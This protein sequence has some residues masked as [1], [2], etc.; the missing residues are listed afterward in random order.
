MSARGRTGKDRVHGDRRLVDA[1]VLPFGHGLRKPD[2]G[3]F[4]IA[5]PLIGRDPADVVMV[6]DDR[7]ADGGA[8]VLGCGV[9]FVDHRP[10]AE[11]PDGLRSLGLVPE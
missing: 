1:Y 2:A 10:V 8:A 3:L 6:G 9:R 4:R 5:C 7:G 11:R